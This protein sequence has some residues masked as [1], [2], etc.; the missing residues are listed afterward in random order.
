MRQLLQELRYLASRI[1]HSQ[2]S[3]PAWIIRAGFWKGLG[4]M[5]AGLDP[6]SGPS[7]GTISSAKP[8]SK[9]GSIGPSVAKDT[10]AP[11]NNSHWRDQT[12]QQFSN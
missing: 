7:S 3:L 9:N 1:D 11:L 12:R 6:G 5:L 10:R 8:N 4:S 2:T